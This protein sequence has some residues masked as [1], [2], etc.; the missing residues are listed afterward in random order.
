MLW[1]SVACHIM[2]AHN[3]TICVL[4]NHEL[5]NSSVE[6]LSATHRVYHRCWLSRW[7]IASI[8]RHTLYQKKWLLHIVASHTKM[9]HNTMHA[10]SPI[11]RSAELVTLHILSNGRPQSTLTAV[12]NVSGRS[13]S[14]SNVI[15]TLCYT[16]GQSPATVQCTGQR[17]CCFPKCDNLR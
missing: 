17:P 10:V 1:S 13:H 3:I 9:I 2:T 14:A 7:H 12:F 6:T 16:G 5:Q 11:S 8:P 4:Q 15:N